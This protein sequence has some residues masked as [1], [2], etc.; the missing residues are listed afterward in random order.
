MDTVNV[1]RVRTAVAKVFYAS[2]PAD[3]MY[4]KLSSGQKFSFPP[5]FFSFK[6]NDDVLVVLVTVQSIQIL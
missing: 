3:D 1:K 4:L 2:L 5:L 6:E